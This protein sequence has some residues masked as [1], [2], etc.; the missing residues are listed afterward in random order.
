MYN[1]REQEKLHPSMYTTKSSP[2]INYPDERPARLSRHHSTSSDRTIHRSREK[3]V[4]SGC[5]ARPHSSSGV[6]GSVGGARSRAEKRSQ[7][8]LR[9]IDGQQKDKVHGDRI[10]N[11]KSMVTDAVATVD[12]GGADSETVT[13]LPKSSTK[14]ETKDITVTTVKSHDTCRQKHEKG[15]S[16]F[17]SK[18]N[19]TKY[20]GSAKDERVKDMDRRRVGQSSK[21][22]NTKE[23]D[24]SKTDKLDRRDSFGMVKSSKGSRKG[25]FRRDSK[26]HKHG[27]QTSYNVG[28]NPD[29]F[30]A[31]DTKAREVRGNMKKIK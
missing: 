11:N 26:P 23:T 28:D 10:N 20:G 8:S 22:D 1:C 21:D 17:A 4:V 19:K 13:G 16:V 24:R 30:I 25:S 6:S 29:K 18:A 31:Q 5:A 15:K 3:R 9:K 2:N 12:K 27:E 7:Y 14:K